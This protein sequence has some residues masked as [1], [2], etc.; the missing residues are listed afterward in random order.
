MT[1]F[2]VEQQS[3]NRKTWVNALR[4]GKY[5]QGTA[6]LK[7][8]NKFCCLGVACELARKDL[9]DVI[10]FESKVT[11]YNDIGDP[12]PESEVGYYDGASQ[13]LPKIVQN[14]LGLHSPAGVYHRDTDHVETLTSVNDAGWSFASIAK[15]IEEFEIS[16]TKGA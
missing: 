8:G 2:T 16:L 15:L 10:D 3:A 13:T 11:M 7:V 1:T 12:I 4:S 5:E 9:G 6:Y 14:W